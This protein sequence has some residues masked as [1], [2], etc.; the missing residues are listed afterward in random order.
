[1]STPETVTLDREL[2]FETIAQLG[3]LGERLAEFQV[4]D[5]KVSEFWGDG[6]LAAI[7]Y[8]GWLIEAMPD[9]AGELEN[10]AFSA[11]Y[12][13]RD[14]AFGEAPEGAEENETDPV[15]VALK[16]RELELNGNPWEAARVREAGTIYPQKKE[17]VA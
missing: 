1:M 2:V 5:Q 6:G 16:A 15:T 11:A 10:R 7:H 17:K 3:A 14:I 13:L 4:Q 8:L 9:Q 12:A